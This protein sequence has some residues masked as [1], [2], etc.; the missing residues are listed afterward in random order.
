ME[1]V[2]RLIKRH[3]P[4]SFLRLVRLYNNREYNNLSNEHVLPKSMKAVLGANLMIQPT[5]FT[6][7]AARVE[8]VKSQLMFNQPLAFCAPS[9]SNRT[10]LT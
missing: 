6:R 7:V 4:D 1:K 3:A 9:K 5:R 10:W 8:T 2:R